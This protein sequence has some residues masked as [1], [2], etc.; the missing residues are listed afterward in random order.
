MVERKIIDLSLQIEEGMPFYPGDPEPHVRKFID[1]KD[2]GYMVHEL[3]IGT[4]TGTHVDVPAHFIP[5]GKT[6]EKIGIEQFIGEGQAFNYN[7]VDPSTEIVIIYTGTNKQWK[8]GWKMDNIKVIDEELAMKLVRS[9]VKLVGIDSPSI[10]SSEVHR[11]LLSNNTVI[12]ENLSD[13]TSL[14]VGKKFTFYAV[15]ILVSG[16]DGAQA[17]AFAVL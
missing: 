4:H 8:K 12:V 11:I 9:K 3:N 2:K 15:P 5:G 13:T 1:Y 7:E 6:L 14:L 10:G 16:V 17:R